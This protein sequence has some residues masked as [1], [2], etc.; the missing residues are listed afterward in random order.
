M[1]TKIVFRMIVADES[2]HHKYIASMVKRI[3]ALISRLKS[4]SFPALLS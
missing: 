2:T 4:V 1:I 3:G